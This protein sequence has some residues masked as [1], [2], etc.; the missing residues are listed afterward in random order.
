[1]ARC[2][3]GKE[4]K[5]EITTKLGIKPSLISV[6]YDGSYRIGLK[7]WAIDK[8]AVEEIA[9]AKQSVRRCEYTHEILSGGNTFVFVDYSLSEPREACVEA[10]KEEIG[11]WSFDERNSRTNREYHLLNAI[12]EKGFSRAEAREAL[13]M[14]YELWAK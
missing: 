5:K 1:M 7:D 2:T 6:R 13:R 3:K 8:E 14:T 4:L 10:T 9:K 11:K 12:S